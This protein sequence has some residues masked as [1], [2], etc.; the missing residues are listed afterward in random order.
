L[1]HIGYVYLEYETIQQ[2]DPDI[3]WG[4]EVILQSGVMGQKKQTWEY[5]YLN[6]ELNGQ[7]LLQEEIVIF[8]QN[9]IISVGTKKV[10]KTITIN[11]EEITYWR[12]IE[13]M[14]ATA[15]DRDCYGCTGYTYTG[16]LLE[17]GMVAV[18]PSVIALG[19]SLYIPGYGHAT[20][21][22]I[23]GSV[24]GN[25]IDLGFDKIENWNGKVSYGKYV[26]V[27]ILD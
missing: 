6:N 1:F 7:K 26:D 18:D 12:I 10:F 19:T 21:E 27:Y 22:D 24:D 13:G 11:G 3:E 4:K 23:G 5:F 9:E 2:K 16:K 14:R 17:K 25:E 20:A 8:P 15:Y